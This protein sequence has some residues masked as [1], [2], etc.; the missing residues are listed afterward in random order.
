MPRPF[1]IALSLVTSLIFFPLLSLA[2]EKENNAT[3]RS[4]NVFGVQMDKDGYISIPKEG[5]NNLDEQK[6]NA[7]IKAYEKQQQDF[8]RQ[9]EQK[10]KEGYR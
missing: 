8:I 4:A 10:L 1:L 2:N 6:Q 9:Q 7:L 5:K 3:D